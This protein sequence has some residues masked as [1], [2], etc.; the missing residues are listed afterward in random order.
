MPIYTKT[1]DKGETSL[2]GGR[3]VSKADPQVEA[4]GTIDELSSFIGLIASEVD[5]KE[6]E[7]YSLIQ[8]DL[9]LVMS[10]LAGAETDINPLDSRIKFFEQYIDKLSSE[11]PD[12]KRFILPQGSRLAVYHHLARTVCRRGE[13]A[14]VRCQNRSATAVVPYLNRLSDL[15]FVLARKYD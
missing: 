8:K 15:L 3:R 10:F 13:R 14:V 11:L 1:G 6:R 9:Y 7:F 5:N 2:Y 12:L 4:C